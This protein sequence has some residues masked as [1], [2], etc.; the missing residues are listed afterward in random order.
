[1]MKAR[2]PLPAA[3]VPLTGPTATLHGGAAAHAD[4]NTNS[5]HW[6]TAGD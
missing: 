3:G 6:R 5:V 4:A 1:M 2:Y